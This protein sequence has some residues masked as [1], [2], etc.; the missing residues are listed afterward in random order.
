MVT[1]KIQLTR[2]ISKTGF[3]KYPLISKNKV[4]T[5]FLFFFTF[6]LLLY[7]KVNCLGP[8]AYF[9][10]QSNLDYSKYQGPPDFL[11]IIGS[12]NF[13]NR[14]FSA[15]FGSFCSVIIFNCISIKNGEQSI[16]S[17]F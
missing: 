12:L 7:L 17:N 10:I 16:I 9:E 5:H 6:Q 15:M 14:Y 8:K 3:S 1:L 2:I 4:W 11:R 13:R